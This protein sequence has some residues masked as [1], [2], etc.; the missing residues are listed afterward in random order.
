MITLA[1]IPS[2]E[3]RCLA[4][5]RLPDPRLRPV[6]HPRRRRRG[7]GRRAALDPARRL[8]RH[9][10]RRRGLGGP[11][12]AGRRPA[13]PRAHR[14]R[15][16]LRRGQGPDH[17]AVHLAR[18]TRHLGRDRS[19]RPRR[20]HR[21]PSPRL[22]GSVRSP[23]RWRRA[24]RWPRRSDG[25]ATGSTRSCSASRPTCRGVWRST[26]APPRR[27]TSSTTTFHPTFLYESL[28]DLGVAGLVIW[29]RSQAAS[30]ATAGPSRCT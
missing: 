23:T 14:P 24:S 27:A 15:A 26:R 25:G 28:W 20:L 3:Q 17:G 29:A 11:V 9:G 4:P 16:V 30:S 22:P 6:H 1:S 21:V 2:P 5:R 7:L 19:R 12:R 8:A 10:R 18:R 13:L